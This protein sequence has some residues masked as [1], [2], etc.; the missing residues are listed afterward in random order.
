MNGVLPIKTVGGMN[1][2]EHHFVRAARVKKERNAACLWVK[3]VMRWHSLPC[4]VTLTRLSAGTL[5]F[6]NLVGSQKGVRDGVADALGVT[7]NHPGIEWRYAQERCH[8]GSYGVMIEITEA[9]PLGLV[10]VAWI[11]KEEFEKM[12][13][14]GDLV[15]LDKPIYWR[16]I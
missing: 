6:D 11:T 15:D 14:E 13:P 9:V 1:A 2:R 12:Y 7:D 4:R 10:P 3:C 5:D 16:L 8:R